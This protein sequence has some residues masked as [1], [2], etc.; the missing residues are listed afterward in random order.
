[1]AACG[2][3]NGDIA[4]AYACRMIFVWDPEKAAANAKKHGVDFHEAATVMEDSLSTTFPDLLHSKGESRYL[5][6]GASTAGRLLV[7]AHTEEGDTIRLINARLATRKE[8]RFYEE[9]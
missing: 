4:E 2:R 6:L 8:R 9:S 3:Y 5:T 7:V 1:M